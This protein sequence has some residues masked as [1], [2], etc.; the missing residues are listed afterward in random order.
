MSEGFSFDFGADPAPV[1]GGHESRTAR[2]EPTPCTDVPLQSLLPHSHSECCSTTEQR[3]QELTVAIGRH[4]LFYQVAPR[5][6]TLTE[7]KDIVPGKYLGGLKVW[8]CAVDL[9]RFLLTS[10]EAPTLSASDEV[11]EVGCGQALPSIAALY[12]GAAR[13]TLH[14]FNSEVLESCTKPNLSKNL[15]TLDTSSCALEVG[16]CAFVHGDWDDFWPERTFQLILGSD[17][18]YDEEACKKLGAMLERC[19]AKDGVALIATKKYYFGTGGGVEE[20]QRVLLEGS[21]R[22]RSETVW[23]SE[24]LNELSRVILRVMW[25]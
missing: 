25:N 19:L 18:T 2:T 24:S 23:E 11:L 16:R 4:T 20:F 13:L 7:D 1:H 17:V 5:L 10:S 8:S 21:G 14:D 15:A 3:T 12:H 9:C 6:T 22:L